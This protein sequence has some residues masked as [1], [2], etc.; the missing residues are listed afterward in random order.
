MVIVVTDGVSPDLMGGNDVEIGR[1]M[2]EAQIVV[3][4][5][6]VAEGDPPDEA[7]ADGRQNRRRRIRG[8][9]P[10]GL[11]RGLLQ[12]R[13][14]CKKRKSNGPSLNSRTT[15]APMPL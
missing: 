4:G 3:Y 5:I 15:S 2:A 14:R 11:G 7:R 1:E 13:T 8:R 12:N 10:I 9:R 6:H